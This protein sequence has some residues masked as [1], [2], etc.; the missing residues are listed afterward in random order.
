MTVVSI[1][2]VWFRAAALDNVASELDSIPLSPKIQ[3]K[4]TR[5][6]YKKG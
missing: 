6:W 2:S 4:T 1:K 5:I 3:K